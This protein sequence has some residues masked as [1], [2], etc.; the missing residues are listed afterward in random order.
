M[1]AMELGGLA[2]EAV[3]TPYEDQWELM[4]EQMALLDHRFYLF[5]KYHQ[6]LGPENDLRNML[7]FV[8]TREEF[9]YNMAKGA[10]APLTARLD[11]EELGQLELDVRSAAL[12]VEKTAHDRIPL[13]QLFDRFE[14]D[15]FEKNCVILAYAALLDEKYEK[16]CAYLQDDISKKLPT[17]SLAVSLFMEGDGSAQA[18]MARFAESRIFTGLFDPEKRKSG[19]LALSKETAGFLNGSMDLPLGFRLFDPAKEPETDKLLVQQDLAGA[20]DS[21]FSQTESAGL[22]SGSEGSGRRF[23]IEQVCRRQ[24]ERCLFVDLRLAGRESET[25]TRA[26]TLARLTDSCLCLSGLETKDAEGNLEPP[27]PEMAETVSK[28]DL[29]RGRLFLLSEK[30]LHLNLDLPT[31]ELELPALDTDERLKLFRAFLKRAKLAKDV[32]LEELAS[33]F[34][35]TP[36]QI[37]LAAHQALSL[38]RVTGKPLTAAQLHQCCYRQVVHKLDTLASRVRPGH[39]WE[40]LVLP[41]A[42]KKLLRQACA[43]VHYQHQIYSEW[44]FQ[45]K[46]AY[47]RGLSILFAGV[48][49]TGKT[50]CAQIMA[51][52]LNMEMYKINISQIVSKYIGETEKNLQAVFR[53]AKN[54]NCIL[55]FDECDA[56]FGKRSEVKDSHDRNANVETAYLL[57]QIEE[58][59]GVCI[60]ATNLLQNIDE[61][62]LRRITFVIHFPFPD[63]EMRRRIYQG[64][65]AEKTPLEEDIDWD[66]LAEKFK[67]SGGYIKNIVLAAAFMA[68]QEHTAVGMRHLLNAAVN[69]MK[70]NE[71]V[72]VR[73]ELREYADLLD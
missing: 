13:L 21:L 66:F 9:E 12:R 5:Y 54:S 58:Y 24:A 18:Y 52:E 26:G 14:L 23:Q 29:Y 3:G 30:P 50:M 73:E 35:F 59:D 51:K 11:G 69:E 32:S 68:A 47:G 71:I 48:P 17:L 33:K 16:L 40:D 7:G 15:D 6:W 53:E 39:D 45:R 25:V 70:K 36:R 38:R 37:K 2:Y 1:D 67:L 31:L 42:Q 57:Q 65:M 72:V 8:V 64:T 20:L 41:E 61:A 49:G 10:Q 63:A 55:F 62:F 34:H 43:H 60:L 56:L 27:A 46:I 44:G 4:R 28:V 19:F 22:L